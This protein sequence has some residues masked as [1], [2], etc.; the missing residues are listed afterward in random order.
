MSSVAPHMRPLGSNPEQRIRRQILL[1]LLQIL[2]LL[3]MGVVFWVAVAAGSSLALKDADRAFGQIVHA[4][5]LPIFLMFALV[6]HVSFRAVGLY[7][8]HR[9]STRSAHLRSV[10]KATSFGTLSLLILATVCRVELFSGRAV[11]IF[12]LGTTLAAATSRIVLRI[13]LGW[14]RRRG[15]NLN[16][17]L[18][19]GT[20]ERAIEFAK[21][22][23]D[24]PELGYRI[25]GFADDEWVGTAG[26]LATGHNMVASLA[27]L[28]TFL[29]QNV[30]HE[31]AICLP[32]QSFYREMLEVA[33][34]C[35][36]QGI[37]TRI[38]ADLFDTKL[39]IARTD[40]FAG[41]PVLTLG[42]AGIEGWSSVCK[43][44]FDRI[45]SAILILLLAPVYVM[46]A[47]LIKL[48]SKGPVFFAQTRL[49]LNKHPF[50]VYKFRTMVVDAEQRRAGL[51][52]LNEVSGPVFK[53]KCDPRVTRVGRVLRK[54][55][56]D[57]L[58]QL[59]NVLKG[60]MSLVGPR[61]LPLHDC[62]GFTT[63]WHLRRFSVRP[64]IS[65][66]W[67]INGRSK[68]GFEEWM[69]MDMK[70]IDQWSFWLDLKILVKTIPAVFKG[71]GAF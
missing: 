7:H 32:I 19:V 63:T 45:V 13:V 33:E 30:I 20:N 3:S 43:I 47:L 36:E 67:Q 4:W 66:L 60:D 56:L 23:N 5:Y 55:S 9:L 8:S 53:L 52:A 40:H 68:I 11:P 49:G 12:W 51:E 69:A 42:E 25:A 39:A 70:Y 18:I 64:G 26:L 34:I 48:T 59:F 10:F 22:I 57:E 2:D 38:L 28:R 6:W 27:T 14:F 44:L 50:R 17:V 31:V 21:S 29:R 16:R 71:E 62:E 58:P 46:I 61:P 37:V 54:L 24:R 35:I 41:C 65:C 1:E 15:K